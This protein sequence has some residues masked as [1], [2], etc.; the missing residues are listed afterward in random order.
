MKE[1]I[2]RLT[3]RL[4]ASFLVVVAVVGCAP[5]TRSPAST[6][7]SDS[8]PH[9]TP[10]RINAAVNGNPVAVLKAVQSNLVSQGQRPAG[11]ASCI[12]A[13]SSV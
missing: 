11:A 5:G 3:P 13:G 6:L 10:R 9:A 2:M 12:R 8:A 7:P 1:R 4:V